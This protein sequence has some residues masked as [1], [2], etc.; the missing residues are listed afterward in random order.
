MITVFTY[1]SNPKLPN[2]KK[3]VW[4]PK[5]QDEKKMSNPRWRPRN[6]CDGRLMV[7]ILIMTIQVNLVPLD[8]GTKLISSSYTSRHTVVCRAAQEAG[9]QPR[10]YIDR[11]K[12]N[13]I[14]AP[15]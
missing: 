1:I 9:A 15:P 13:A 12:E 4:P 6:G 7:K 11:K 14:F 8:L 3:G 2:C 5:G 10:E